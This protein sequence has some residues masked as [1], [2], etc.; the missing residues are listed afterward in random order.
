MSDIDQNSGHSAHDASIRAL[1]RD[2]VSKIKS[3]A[4]ITHLNDAILGLIKNALD[5]NAHTIT[6]TVDFQRGGCVVEDDGDGIPPTE[7]EVDGGL[8]KAYHTSKFSS[9]KDFFGRKGLFLTSLASLSLL[10]ITS[11]HRHR[12]TTNTIMFHHSTPVA[13]LIPAPSQHQLR[14][15]SHGTKVSVNDIFGNMPVRVKS[16]ALALRKPDELDREWDNL[17]HVVA[18]IVLANDLIEKLVLSHLSRRKVIFR[19]SYRAS[20]GREFD[21]RRVTSILQ[22]AGLIGARDL[23]H[24]RPVSASLPDLSVHAIIS[25]TP[26]PT[27]KVQFISLENSPVFAGNQ[28]SIFYNEINQLFASSDFG[29][30]ASNTGMASAPSTSRMEAMDVKGPRKSVGKWPMF[31]IRIAA[32]GAQTLEDDNCDISPESDGSFQRIMDVLVAMITEFLRQ[33][34]LRPRS[35]RQKRK[36]FEGYQDSRSDQNFRKET[37]KTKVPALSGNKDQPASASTEETLDAR[38]KLPSFQNMRKVNVSRDFGGWSRVKSG[39][40]TTVSKLPINLEKESGMLQFYPDT[41]LP[42]G[43]RIHGGPSLT[44]TVPT[45]SS[46]LARQIE[47]SAG[48]VPEEN[49]EPVDRLI[50][51][52]DSNTG[53]PVSLG[54]RTDNCTTADYGDNKLRSE[55]GHKIRR[56]GSVPSL[57]PRNKGSWLEKFLE[58]WQNPVFGRP[59]RA[60][61]AVES[62][63]GAG[64]PTGDVF[65]FSQ[66][67]FT[68]ETARLGSYQG[69]ISRNQL[70]TATVIAQVDQK[71]I[72]TKMQVTN[73]KNSGFMLAL[74]DQHAADERCRIEQ[75]FRDLVSDSLQVQTIAVKPIA[76]QV[77]PREA[78]LL[79]RASD[80]FTRWGIGYD[81]GL[82]EGSHLVSVH[83][84]PVLIAE[85]CRLESSLVLDL[86]RTEIWA[87]EENGRGPSPRSQ[88]GST[89][90]PSWLEWISRCPRGI[91]DL[92]ISRACRTAI[93]F[94]DELTLDDCQ[95]LVA[96]LATCVFPFQCAHGRPT[97]VPL[98]NLGGDRESV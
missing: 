68:L 27:K 81:V 93:M 94:N 86:L 14:W 55:T 51:C 12:P 23:S 64:L 66:E 11:K 89:D 31:Y 88:A 59:E 65:G 20:S 30:M 37:N 10:T 19:P 97:M 60:I 50:F 98:V 63:R 5:A 79:R 22:Q 90:T 83:T 36:F 49:G 45:E 62:G 43:A 13:R 2:V 85:R 41:D 61:A 17:K 71:F 92:L 82:Q 91:T 73:G 29:L 46:S 32:R 39:N 3:S 70:Q 54:S 69:R 15:S 44:E 77:S 72:L 25:L 78:T 35:E 9:E 58:Q 21:A 33:H 38:L 67:S 74:I 75:L 6:V 57:K 24:W 80:F 52:A 8:G 42:R 1:P 7:F 18:S 95:Q 26:S 34:G 4:S 40:G 16:R 48:S 87:R 76:F 56:L 28:A 84:L 96:R 53:E 47:V